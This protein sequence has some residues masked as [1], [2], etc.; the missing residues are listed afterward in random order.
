MSQQEQLDL[1]YRVPRLELPQRTIREQVAEHL[2]YF[3][4]RQAARDARRRRQYERRRRKGEYIDMRVKFTGTFQGRKGALNTGGFRFPNPPYE[5]IEI[6]R[7]AKLWYARANDQPLKLEPSETHGTM[8][9]AVQEA[10]EHQVHPWQ[11]CDAITGAPLDP[12]RV[13]EDPA[14]NFKMRELTHVSIIGAL[15]Q[16]KRGPNFF[17]TVC[18]IEVFVKQIKSARSKTPPECPV[19]RE[20]WAKTPESERLKPA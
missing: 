10:F 11:I 16:G 19:C 2:R 3:R 1:L 14:G 4:V 17:N 8:K 6:Y 13:E 12:S 7:H 9:D 18:G 15:A 5:Y 20:V